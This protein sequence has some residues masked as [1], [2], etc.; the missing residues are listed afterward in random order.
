MLPYIDL[1]LANYCKVAFNYCLGLAMPIGYSLWFDR[2]ALRAA[3]KVLNLNL[4]EYLTA[5]FF[6][7]WSGGKNV[8]GVLA[9]YAAIPR[10][11]ALS[12]C[13]SDPADVQ[14][15]RETWKTLPGC[16]ELRHDFIPQTAAPYALYKDQALY[17]LHPVTQ[18]E[19][20]AFYVWDLGDCLGNFLQE[21]DK[22]FYFRVLNDKNTYSEYAAVPK[23][24]GTS[25]PYQG[26]VIPVQHAWCTVM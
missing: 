8:S 25:I 18:P 2:E 12:L 6:S 26:G 13:S 5:L 7:L 14:A 17:R 3:G 4:D 19:R 22:A 20:A 9:V 10:R 15:I 11:S 21:V 16:L 23:N 24:P 1:R